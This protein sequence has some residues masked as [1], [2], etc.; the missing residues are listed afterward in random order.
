MDYQLGTLWPAFKGALLGLIRTAPE[1]RDP[2]KIEASVRATA[3]VLSILEAHLRDHDFVAGPSL[4][5]GDI[6]LGSSVYRWLELDI[7]GPDL[8]AIEAWHSRLE[9]RPAYQR[10]V[11]VS[12][13][14][15]APPHSE[16]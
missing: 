9:D 7:E 2:A 1:Q 8:P 10:T 3:E 14:K 6:S 13:V 4:T 12:F 15:E 16:I 5:M 11:M